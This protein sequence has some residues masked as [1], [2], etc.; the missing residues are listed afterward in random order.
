MSATPS[1]FK[2]VR[3]PPLLGRTFDPSEGEV[4]HD[5]KVILSYGLWQRL[6]SGDFRAPHSWQANGNRRDQNRGPAY[7]TTACG[8]Q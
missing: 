1:T 8:R 2:L 3:V 7:P 4:G 5:R 6:Y